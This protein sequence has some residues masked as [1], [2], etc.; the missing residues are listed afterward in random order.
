[1]EQQSCRLQPT[2]RKTTTRSTFARLGRTTN[3][4][5]KYHLDRDSPVKFLVSRPHAIFPLQGVGELLRKCYYWKA[6]AMHYKRLL[7]LILLSILIPEVCCKI[8]EI[9]SAQEA[10]KNT[11]RVGLPSYHFCLDQQDFHLPLLR[12]IIFRQ[13]LYLFLKVEHYTKHFNIESLWILSFVLQTLLNQK[14]KISKSCTL[15]WLLPLQILLLGQ[16]VFLFRV[17]NAVQP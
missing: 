10:V 13:L 15:T 3:F 16:Q 5:K 6:E 4:S 8:C 9:G 12:L 1:M 7:L 11:G 14:T 17:A 2:K